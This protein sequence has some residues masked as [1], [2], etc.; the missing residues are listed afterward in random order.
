MRIS[1]VTLVLRD[2]NENNVEKIVLLLR[3]G[4]PYF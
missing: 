1:V 3:D 2:E 4:F